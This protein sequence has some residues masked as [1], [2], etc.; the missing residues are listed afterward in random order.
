M[1]RGR[2]AH[3]NR[4][5]LYEINYLILPDLSEEDTNSLQEKI[6]NW[7]QEEK[8]VVN[9]LS[10]PVKKIL[11]YPIKK[12]GQAY[13]GFVKFQLDADKLISI[14]KKIKTEN[15]II[16]YLILAKKTAK[17]LKIPRRKIKK[18]ISPIVKP[19]MSKKDKIELESIEQKLDEILKES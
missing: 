8:G 12:C 16:R 3:Y 19:G 10:K 18:F 7:I 5:K 11:A 15:N 2:G 13:L 9:E 14:E 4:M 1:L 6:N 17:P